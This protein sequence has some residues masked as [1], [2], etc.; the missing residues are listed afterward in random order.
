MR[1][2]LEKHEWSWGMHW[3]EVE[4]YWDLKG[5]LNKRINK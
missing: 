4:D 1:S 2:G 3:R 5:A